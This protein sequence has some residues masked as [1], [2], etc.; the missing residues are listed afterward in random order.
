M[1][2]DGSK[3]SVEL[4]FFT[5]AYFWAVINDVERAKENALVKNFT[6]TDFLE[7]FRLHSPNLGTYNSHKKF[8]NSPFKVFLKFVSKKGIINM[9]TSLRSSLG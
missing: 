8:L 2:P 5:R 3:K 1:S 9:K 7:P 6:S 4:K